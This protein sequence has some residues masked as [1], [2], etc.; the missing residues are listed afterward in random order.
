MST[1]SR[2]NATRAV[3]TDTRAE[4]LRR[5]SLPLLEL[6]QALTKMAISKLTELQKRILLIL[7]R[8]GNGEHTLSSLVRMLSTELRV[9]ESTLKWNLRGLRDVGLIVS[10][11][12]KTKG[13]PVSLTYAGVVVARYMA[14]WGCGK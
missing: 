10:G 7:Y 2:K 14:E 9:S 3:L 12:A 11:S 8:K 1:F 4:S 13:L 6:E 5:E